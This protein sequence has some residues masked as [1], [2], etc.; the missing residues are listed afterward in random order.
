MTTATTAVPTT[1]VPSDGRD[2]RAGWIFSTPFLVLY[3]L[4]LIGPVL[5][6]LV[7]SFFNTATVK[8]DLGAFVG[9]DNYLDILSSVDFW[10]SM[11]HSTLFTLLTV[12][13]LV[14]LPLLAAVFAARITRNRW[15]Y[16]VAFFAPY[17]VPSASV[18]LIF[19]YIYSPEIGLLTKAF[20]S[21]GLPDPG[22]LS[23]TKGAWF[24]VTLMTVWWT[25]G[26]NFVLYTAALQ[27]IP[28]E[29]Y[30]AAAIDGASAWQQIRSITVPLLR[31][32]IGLV[33]MLQV[34]ASLKVFDQIY[35]LLG[36]GPNGS[37]RPVIEYIYDTGFTTYRAGY[38]A[39]GTMVY[40]LILVLVS[41]VWMITSRR[42]DARA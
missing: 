13:F 2:N 17:V 19:S 42:R 12:P 22:F 15:F 34:L 39:A 16:R 23:A 4:F 40:F 31:P 14:V 35:I 28:E 33:L 18:A 9:L 24:A 36:G 29:T 8:N 1:R 6:G 38:A 26:F 3:A 10:K 21:V 7:L 27:E 32:T 30:E 37:T 25:F 41:A 5:V 20:T 11:W